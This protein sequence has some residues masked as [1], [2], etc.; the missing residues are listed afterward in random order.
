MTQKKEVK[1][2]YMRAT[3]ARKAQKT[4][5]RQSL[6]LQKPSFSKQ[7]PYTQNPQA[8]ERHMLRGPKVLKCLKADPIYSLSQALFSVRS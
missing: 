6:S 5:E 2:K 1:H 8:N 4:N 7:L 3:E